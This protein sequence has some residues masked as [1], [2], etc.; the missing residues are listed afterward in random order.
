MDPIIKNRQ[1]AP[2]FNLPDLDGRTHTLEEARGRVLV[3]NF[4]SAECP[5]AQRADEALLSY[6]EEWGEKVIL[7][8]VASNANEPPELLR[9]VAV[10]RG[11]PL[12]LHDASH[13]MAGQYGA[14]TSPHLYVIDQQGILRYQ[15]AIDNVTFRQREPSRFYLREAVE[16]V[17]GGKEPDPAQTPPLGCSLVFFSPGA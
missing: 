1:P 2:D 11:L 3:L 6:K 10:E 17:L 12:V 4:W 7:W 8:P 14:L 15:G 16:A 9:K 13:Q 5:W